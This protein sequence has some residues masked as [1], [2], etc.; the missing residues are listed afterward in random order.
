[1]FL[2]G[3]VGFWPNYVMYDVIKLVLTGICFYYLL[4]GTLW[5][6]IEINSIKAGLGALGNF[7][8]TRKELKNESALRNDGLD[9]D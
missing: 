5:N 6:K 4:M 8:Q 1:M 2:I 9:S 7:N 3:T